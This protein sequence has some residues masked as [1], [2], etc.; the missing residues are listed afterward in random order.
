MENGAWIKSLYF[1]N[2]RRWLVEVNCQ[3]FRAL[4]V[5]TLIFAFPEQDLGRG[6]PPMW[7]S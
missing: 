7:R 6:K 1:G 5:S 4:V 3:K 2:A